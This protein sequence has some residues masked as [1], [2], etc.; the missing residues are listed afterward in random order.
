MPTLGEIAEVIGAAV[1]EDRRQ[2]PVV[3][4]GTVENPSPGRAVFVLSERYLKHVAASE[5]AVLFV[6]PE[7]AS[8]VQAKAPAG[9]LVVQVAQ[10]PAALERLLAHL[11]QPLPRPARGVHATAIIAESAQLGT[12]VAIGPNVLIGERAKLGDCCILHA[13]VVIADE[14]TLGDDCELFPG[15]VVRERCDI[16][17]RVM[18]HANSVIGSD[19]FGY[20]WDGSRHARQVHIGTVVLEDDVE[21]GACTCIDRAKIG[22]TRVGAGTKIDNLVQIGHN[23]RIGRHCIVCGGVSVGGTTT[24]ADHVI[25]AG[26]AAVA[27]HTV[28]EKGSRALGLAGVHGQVPA[29]ESVVGMPAVPHR[30]FWR[31]QASLRRLPEALKT[32]KALEARIAQLETKLSGGETNTPGA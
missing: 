1:P 16:G 21:V 14:A 32:I 24:L 25:L 11:S 20:R 31:A 10:A 15:A 5:A 2:M 8:A 9:M 28:F 7:L 29:G 18:I 26:A 17:N 13:G 4:L 30:E 6:S 3:G 12:E 19:G 22:E 27:D 23:V